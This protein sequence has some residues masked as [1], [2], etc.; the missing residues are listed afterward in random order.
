M[1]TVAYHEAIPGHHFQIAI[2]QELDLPMFR[3]DMG[4]NGY[5]EGWALYAERLAWELG[6]YEDDPYG[7]LGR[8]QLELLRAVRLVTDTSIHAMHWTREEAKA[9]M[10]EALGAR[11]GTYSHE[12][13]RYIVLPGQATSYKVGMLKML[14]LRQGA[15]DE[16]GD[17][18]DLKEFHSVLLTNGSMPLD[19]LEQ[20]VQD[21]IDTKSTT[22]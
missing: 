11:P 17:Q 12:V 20:A 19:I 15:M 16:L 2:A 18:F 1:A 5:V 4:F 3:K 8:L 21:Y 10:D 7:N 14:E 6:L 22:P 9:Y 13:D